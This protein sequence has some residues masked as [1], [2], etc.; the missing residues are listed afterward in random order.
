[1]SSDGMAG[2]QV[3][4]FAS[5]DLAGYDPVIETH[6]THFSHWNLAA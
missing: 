3:S 5:S 1:M 2:G 4:Y 6:S